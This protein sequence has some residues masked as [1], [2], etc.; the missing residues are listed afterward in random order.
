MPSAHFTI[1]HAKLRRV[2]VPLHEPFRISNGSVAVKE[3]IVIE[4]HGEGL[5]AFGEASPMSGSFY[6][7][8]T[9]D[10]TWNA[11]A[12]DLIP[13]L[14]ARDIPG[15]VGNAE[16]VGSY[17]KE[18]F[19]RAGIEGAVWHFAALRMKTSIGS[20]FGMRQ[21]P[22]RS[23]LAIGLYD[24]L[25]DLKSAIEKYL[26]DGYQRLKIKIQ[27]GWDIAPLEMVRKYFPNVPLM[28]DANASYS[29][30]LHR[31]ILTSL[32]RFD[33]MMIEQPLAKDA[34]E[35]AAELQRSIRT[36]LCA[37]E[38]AESMEDLEQ[39][40]LLKSAQI[41]NIKVQRVGGLW[42]TRKMHDRARAANLRLWL[43]T[44][45]E[46]GIASAQA[47]QIASLPGFR[48]PTDIEA[49]DR[50]FVDD[51]ISPAICIDQKGFIHLPND[52]GMGYEV[53]LKKL[54]R[55]TTEQKVFWK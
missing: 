23:G 33:L 27:P 54:E 1:D 41:I 8:E 10:S 47:L 12:T 49:S 15:P 19:A 17:G 9:P 4:L 40:I 52:L 14:L 35:D 44:M 31:D 46:L 34:I 48:Y 51:L 28:V 20:L 39:I 2:R 50:W 16:V 24:T 18:P 26:P 30:N 6:S 11:L 55:F 7:S 37:D 29:L 36:P 21:K 22:L 38:S 3:S 25:D 32:D 43:G 42:N 5:T 45:P 13:D 53:D